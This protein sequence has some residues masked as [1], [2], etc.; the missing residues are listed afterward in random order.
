KDATLGSSNLY[1]D[2]YTRFKQGTQHLIP[3]G[4]TFE[5]FVPA[6]HITESKRAVMTKN[7]SAE[8]RRRWM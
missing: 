7:V 1:L 3:P 2:W 4:E 8:F 5:K 6:I